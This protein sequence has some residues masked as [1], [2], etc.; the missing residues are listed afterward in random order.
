MARELS[1]IG[2]PLDDIST[3]DL[4]KNTYQNA[5]FLAAV[6]KPAAYDQIY[7]VTSGFHMQRSLILFSHFG[8]RANPAPSDRLGVRGRKL[9][10]ISQNFLYADL[11]LHEFGGIVQFYLYNWYGGNS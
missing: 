9:T 2:V 5:K 3:E 11:C 10:S 6:I 7:L 4:S 8:I 1:E